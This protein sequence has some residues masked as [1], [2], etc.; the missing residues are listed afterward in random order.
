[1]AYPPQSLT[2][3]LS[4]KP[5]D[6]TPPP[7]EETDW[8]KD[9]GLSVSELSGIQPQGYTS[10]D[11]A[12]QNAIKYFDMLYPASNTLDNEQ[13]V[14]T[15]LKFFNTNRPKQADIF[16][17]INQKYKTRMFSTALNDLARS[18]GSSIGNDKG[19]AHIPKENFSNFTNDLNNYFGILEKQSGAEY[20]DRVAEFNYRLQQM[21]K[22]KDDEQKRLSQRAKT[23]QTAF[24]SE[25]DRWK[26][27]AD[28]KAMLQQQ[29][30][31]FDADQ[32]AKDRQTR[33]QA[34]YIR[35]NGNNKNDNNNKTYTLTLPATLVKISG[36]KGKN[37]ADLSIN[38]R[39]ASINEQQV[40]SLYWDLMEY[41]LNADNNDAKNGTAIDDNSR[42]TKFLMIKSVDNDGKQTLREATTTGERLNAI[43]NAIRKHPY[44]FS[45]IFRTRGYAEELGI[46]NDYEDFSKTDYK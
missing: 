8:L 1:M 21:G 11:A 30:F 5:A 26:Y 16:K 34:A 20:A 13:K 36:G 45:Y 43:N 10:A 39:T 41:F 25:L 29:K 28:N 12:R 15:A 32:K 18:I 33:L 27:K 38:Q 46:M 2:D 31:L 14:D 4:P 6:S 23:A 24:D 40:E 7:Q 37:S 44:S 22:I 19:L 35:G 42:R 9:F 3:L 17:D